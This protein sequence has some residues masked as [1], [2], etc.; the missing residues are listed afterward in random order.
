MNA[1]TARLLARVARAHYLADT[2][3]P[4]QPEASVLAQFKAAWDGMAEC[5]VAVGKKLLISKTRYEAWL[6]DQA[7]QGRAAG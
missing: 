7:G 5:C 3:D 6:A 1:R 2:R 4:R